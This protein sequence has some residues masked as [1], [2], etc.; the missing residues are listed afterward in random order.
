LNGASET[1]I[2]EIR[3]P[4]STALGDAPDTGNSFLGGIAGSVGR[5]ESVSP[6]ARLAQHSFPER[7]AH[8]ESSLLFQF[9]QERREGRHYALLFGQL[10]NAEQTQCWNSEPSGNRAAPKLIHERQAG[11]LLRRQREGRSLSMNRSDS[12]NFP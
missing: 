10:E 7:T 3:H 11:A 6:F 5:A 1:A 8:P 12:G 2:C 9:L 4:I